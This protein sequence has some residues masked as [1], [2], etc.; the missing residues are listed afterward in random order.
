MDGQ[1]ERTARTLVQMLRGYVE[2]DP[3][4]WAPYLLVA[5]LAYNGTVQESLRA[6]PFSLVNDLPELP[7]REN[8][9]RSGA[10]HETAARLALAED[11][12]AE[13]QEAQKKRNEDRA[14]QHEVLQAGDLVAI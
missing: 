10:L 6:A 5:E 13:A 7:Q 1:T 9:S 2:N 8:T 12:M 3:T 4:E 11:S 14:H